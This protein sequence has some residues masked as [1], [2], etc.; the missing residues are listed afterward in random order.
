MSAR[1]SLSP[2]KRHSPVGDG[3]TVTVTGVPE[4]VTTA[5]GTSEPPMFSSVT[6]EALWRLAIA[7]RVGRGATSAS[8]VAARLS[9][10]VERKEKR[11]LEERDR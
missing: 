7:A 11:I 1:H 10:S 2:P 6:G 9:V 5:T 4:R 3:S 8:A